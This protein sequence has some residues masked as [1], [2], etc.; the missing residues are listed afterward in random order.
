MLVVLACSHKDIATTALKNA[1]WIASLKHRE[2][3]RFIVAVNQRGA[4]Q[5]QPVVDALKQQFRNV[6]LFVP[7]DEE[8]R[9]WP[10]AQNHM[11]DRV[12]RYVKKQKKV[13]WLWLESDAILLTDY[14]LDHLEVNHKASGKSFSGM[15]VD[16]RSPHDGKPIP[17]HMSGNGIYPPDVFQ[18]SRR[19]LEGGI[20]FDMVLADSI[21][22]DF[23]DTKLVHHVYQ[24]PDFEKD[25]DLLRIKP[26]AVLFHQ[27]KTG[28]LIDLLASKTGW[29]P[30]H[31]KPQATPTKE[32]PSPTPALTA[33]IT[34]I[35]IKTYPA[36]F[37]WL[38]YCL[39]SIDKFCS[40]FRQVNIVTP[41]P[42][43]FATRH[44]V[45]IEPDEGNG[46][47]R[48]QEKKCHADRYTDADQILFMDSD[49]VFI[50]DV[51]P[52]TFLRDGKPIWLKTPWSHVRDQN[53]RDSWFP[54][55]TNFMGK[56]PAFEFMR[57]HP[58]LV[59]VWLLKALRKSCEFMHNQQLSDY[60][61]EGA[62]FSEFN[63]LGA[64]AHTAPHH[65]K[66][67]WIDTTKDEVP[68]ETVLQHWSKNPIDDAVRAKLEAIVGTVRKSESIPLPPQPD[69]PPPDW[70]TAPAPHIASLAALQN[71]VA[72][73]SIQTAPKSWGEETDLLVRR[74]KELCTAPVHIGN[75]R[76][77]LAVTG[78][79]D[80]KK[81]AKA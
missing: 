41:E 34:D 8:E 22:G 7:Y 77:K 30:A 48:Q 68:S 57:R 13:P 62:A 18:F 35:L 5:A 76:K 36:D 26:G 79:I 55:I 66:F 19:G 43:P 53:A 56:Q 39:R 74:L 52:G 65:D 20:A 58:F 38:E 10:Y 42:L 4:A 54:C 70:V 33:M 51:Y 28:K 11:F 59:P 46:Y 44:R 81:K 60:I 1:Q 75:I 17:K 80:G 72:E 40:G 32:T 73:D 31:L 45:I 67:F 49:C 3:H 63:V 71:A 47:L 12:A 21:L 15:L 23:N 64:L 29:K 69:A 50:R 6:E 61:M 2:D 37:G 25:A 78:L 9:A 16:T 14:A 27:C 24:A